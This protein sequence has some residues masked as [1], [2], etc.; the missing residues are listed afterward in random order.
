MTTDSAFAPFTLTCVKEFLLGLKVAQAYPAVTS[1]VVAVVALLRGDP[2][3][4]ELHGRAC[5]SAEMNLSARHWHAWLVLALFG[6]G[7]LHAVCTQ[8]CHPAQSPPF[9]VFCRQTCRHTRIQSSNT[10]CANCGLRG[11]YSVDCPMPRE[12][13]NDSRLRCHA[14]GRVGHH[15]ANEPYCPQHEHHE[16]FAILMSELSG[17]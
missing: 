10:T 6:V 1:Q 2:G 16:L 17:T 14:C 15:L 13:G 5:S 3:A 8:P 4:P 7:P 9:V 11:C 12:Q